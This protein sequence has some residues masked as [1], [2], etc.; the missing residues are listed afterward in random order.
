MYNSL[1]RNTG[2]LV[3]D[4]DKEASRVVGALGQ[5]RNY[6]EGIRTSLADA[7]PELAQ[8]V[9][10]SQGF[11]EVVKM[12]A[13]AQEQITNSLKTNILLTSEQMIA[14]VEVQKA[15][16]ITKEELG[17]LMERFVTAG[18]SVNQFPKVMEM[19]A[20]NARKVGVNV[21]AVMTNI[22]NGLDDI[23]SNYNF[24]NT[25]LALLRWNVDE[26][27]NSEI[28]SQWNVPRNDSQ[29]TWIFKSPI[30]FVNFC[31]F[32]FI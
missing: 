2:G 12:A 13:D 14:I 22:A 16:S 28:F 8:I 15:Y 25:L 17:I 7:V 6:A 4:L 21:D 30:S 10:S 32:I 1:S 19:A 27:G 24:D 9:A 31:F 5:S 18:N 23:N 26:N 20:N 11:A 29:D 3:R